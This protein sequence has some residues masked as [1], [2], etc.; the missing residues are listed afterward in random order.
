MHSIA[1][2][3]SAGGAAQYFAKDDYYLGEGPG[4][5]SEWG[6]KGAA[7][8]GLDGE[9][10]RADFENL[11]NSILPDG[12]LVNGAENKSHGLDLTFSL[13]KSASVLALV[14]G[15]SRILEAHRA[16]VTATMVWAE[17]KFAE[18]R[19]YSRV[20]KG[21]PIKTGNLV[22]ALFEHDT[23]RK[24]DPQS[25][26]HV[27]VAAIT[28]TAQG[29]WKALWNGELWRNNSVIGS[30]YHAF[31][32]A[33]MEKLGYETRLTGKHGQYEIS[34]VSK[35]VIQAF[36]RRREEIVQKSA[37]L[38]ISTPQG[39]DRVVVNTRDAKL[40]VDDKEALRAD[41][42]RRAAQLGFDCKPLIEA[43][44]ARSVTHYEQTL[45]SPERVQSILGELRDTLGQYFRASDPLA[46][47]GMKR[48]GLT[49][50]ELRTEIAVAS[51]VRIHGQREAAFPINQI[52]KTA[53]DLG[54]KDV[55]ADK[56]DARI[57]RLIRNDLVVPGVTDRIDGLISHV[58]T[59]EH[60]A[61]ER[62]LLTEI[63]K[64]RGAQLPALNPAMVTQ[65]LQ[66]AAAER[67]LNG[68]QLGA[69]TLALTTRD[70]ISVIQ[71][72]AGAGKTTLIEAVSKVAREE[73]KEV[74]GL[75][76]ANKMVGM[77]RD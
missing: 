14:A 24:L 39:Q 36:S 22:Y 48:I 65:R 1:S 26:I 23:S 53:L 57:S 25:H 31:S 77:L 3:G 7:E 46:T 69:A 45:G 47:N 34:G 9:V 40:N 70:R 16:A 6:G 58:T 75:A 12:T 35:E 4:E 74:L 29:Q 8:L 68:E 62:Q 5:L 67:P 56:V 18:A 19:D 66:D 73:G 64:G 44:I 2:V 15:D 33:E 60:I 59:H 63:D 50:S 72:V 32:R 52:A 54:L 27:V 61:Q 49:P 51:A 11:L 37:E 10:K 13:P 42:H 28:Q 76:F 43:A 38:G 71:G 30:A 17:Q 41:W 21:E 20:R 55:T